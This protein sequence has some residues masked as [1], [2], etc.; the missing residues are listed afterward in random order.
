MRRLQLVA[1]SLAFILVFLWGYRA[2]VVPIYS[3]AGF[4]FKWPGIEPMAW[5]TVLCFIP[6]AILPMELSKPSVLVLWWLYVTAYV[7]SLIMPLITLTI[8]E[9]TAFP[10]QLSVLCAMLLLCCVP[11]SKTLVLPSL[12]MTRTHFWWL[13]GFAWG[14]CILF[15]L[16]SISLSRVIANIALLFAG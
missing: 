9:S 13:L 4:I 3:Y 14:G 15:S 5:V 12:A 7:P 16:N 6:L 11:Y 2:T 8:P 1:S 10:L